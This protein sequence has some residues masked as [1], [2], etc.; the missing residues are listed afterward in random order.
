MLSSAH[1]HL[2]RKLPAHGTS[3]VISQASFSWE[4]LPLERSGTC[5]RNASGRAYPPTRVDKDCPANLLKYITPP[6][7]SLEIR[8]RSQL[9]LTC[10]PQAKLFRARALPSSSQRAPSSCLTRQPLVLHSMAG[11]GLVRGDLC[12]VED[13]SVQSRPMTPGQKAEHRRATRGFM[14]WWRLKLHR[15]ASPLGNSHGFPH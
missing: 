2:A 6:P 1:N 7:Q 9:A 8:R 14:G 5:G 3:M 13:P 15:H 12:P 11:T 4:S 10:W